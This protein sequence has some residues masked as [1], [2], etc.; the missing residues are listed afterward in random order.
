M[1]PRHDRPRRRVYD[2]EKHV[3]FVTFSCYR[4]RKLLE[5]DRAKRIVIGGLGSYLAADGGLC[6]GF[7]VMPDHVHAMIWFPEVRRLSR[8][9]NE[10]KSRTSATIK[11][12]YRRS[13]PNYSAT[14]G[15]ADPVWQARYY[16]FNVFTRGKAE[17]KLDYMHLNPVRA[18]LVERAIDWR[19]S[20][21]RWYLEGRPVGLPIRWPPEFE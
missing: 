1:N 18:G 8:F 3:Q 5:P 11:E 20:S 10:W 4:R 17:G 16:G 14:V 15:D 7:V 19:W 12:L 9:M 13:F 21:A 2:D 6:L